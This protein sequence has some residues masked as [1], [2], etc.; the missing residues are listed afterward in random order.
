VKRKYIVRIIILLVIVAAVFIVIKYT[1]AGQYL[2][3]RDIFKNR[4]ALITQVQNRYLLSSIVYTLFYIVVVA[5]SIPGASILTI[6]GGFFFGPIIAT[7]YINIG[8]TVGA[9]IIFIAARFFIGEMVQKKYEEKLAKFN[10]EI[11]KNGKN[12]LLTLRLIPIFPFFLINLFA[13]VTKIKPLTFLWTTSL[14]IIPGSFAYAYSGYAVAKLGAEP[15]VPKNLIFAFLLLA[16]LSIVPVVYKKIKAR[17]SRE[18]EPVSTVG[19]EVNTK[20]A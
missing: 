17:R 14:G 15:G 20:K 16:V 7:L 3:I 12:Y 19:Q 6:L 11:E 13:G 5:L 8:A 9:L 18:K 1:S 10:K 2:N 4:D